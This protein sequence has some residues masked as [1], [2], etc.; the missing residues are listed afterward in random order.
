MKGSR[1]KELQQASSA[2]ALTCVQLERVRKLLEQSAI[3][4]SEPTAIKLDEA[5]MA[6]FEAIKSLEGVQTKIGEA[7]DSW[8]HVSGP[9]SI[10]K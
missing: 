3:E 9:R 5:F 4:S 1:R 10:L 2:V 6:V 8:N 7:L